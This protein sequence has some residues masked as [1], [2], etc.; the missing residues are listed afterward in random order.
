MWH[1]VRGPEATPRTGYRGVDPGTFGDQ[2]D[3]LTREATPVGWPDVEAAL[4]GDRRLPSD[5]V[6]LTFDDGLVD[7]HRVVLPALAQRG[8]TATFFVLAR[9]PGDG[10]TLGHRIHV[11]LGVC[12][13]TELRPAI[14]D[15]LEPSARARY[16]AL[17]ERLRA[18]RP[19]D[20]DD[21]WKRPLQR[22]LADVAGP[23]LS[24][25][26]VE[27]LGP[28]PDVA[29]DLHL[30][31]RQLAALIAAG[32]TIGGHGRA[33]PWLDAI[34]PTAVRAEIAASGRHLRAIAPGPWPFAYPYG[35]VPRGAGSILGAAGFAA[36]FTTH[37]DRRSDRF[38]IGRRDG[39]DPDWAAWRWDTV[40]GPSR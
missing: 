1:Y 29:A 12:S 27:R 19:D 38:H 5:A 4:A 40:E 23:V 7:H 31:P 2:L 6:L 36:G 13:S 37:P 18:A 33:H 16:H 24:R 21:V 14:E 25:L 30:G 35:G 22:E 8:L 32:M 9:H 15:G 10:L 28:E 34:G 11:L 39:D 17:Q 26:V 20:P 3:A